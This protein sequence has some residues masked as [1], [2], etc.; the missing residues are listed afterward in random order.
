[1]ATLQNDTESMALKTSNSIIKI[2]LFALIDAESVQ[3][4]TITF[5][6]AKNTGYINY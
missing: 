6:A 5:K 3:V 2:K 1:M 4:G